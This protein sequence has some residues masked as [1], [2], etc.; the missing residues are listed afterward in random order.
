MIHVVYPHIVSGPEHSPN[1]GIHKLRNSP[2]SQAMRVEG[3][4][5]KERAVALLLELRLR[6]PGSVDLL[7]TQLHFFSDDDNACQKLSLGSLDGHLASE[8]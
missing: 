6:A 7:L 4:A 8:T 2:L 5:D 1:Q 3:F